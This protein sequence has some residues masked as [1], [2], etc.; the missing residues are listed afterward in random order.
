MKH[1]KPDSAPVHISIVL[2]RSGSM[3]SIADD[4]VG[5]FNEFLREQRKRDG[6]ARVT[7]VQFDGQDPFEILVDGRDLRDVQDL[8]RDRYQPR[9]MTPLLDATGRMILRID[10]DVAAR[11]RKGEPEEDQIVVVV[12]DGL[13]NASTEHTRKG[14]FELIEQRRAQGWAFVFLGADQ[15][16]YAEGTRMGVAGHNAAA[17]SKDKPGI[18]KMWR[19]VEHS[20]TLHRA[21]P[22]MS[23]RM[24]ADVFYQ[25]EEEETAK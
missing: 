14:V 5:G 7:L 20:A 24:D 9:G 4:I 8:T 22:R 17:W 10:N 23:R 1:K 13:E 19:E 21:K 18:D 3:A 12:T 6:E 11:A 15:D 16:A 2:D 25:R